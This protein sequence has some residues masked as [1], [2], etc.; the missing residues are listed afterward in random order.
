[1]HPRRRFSDCRVTVL[2]RRRSKNRASGVRYQSLRD[3]ILK[4]TSGWLI[5]IL[6][7]SVCAQTGIALAWY[8]SDRN[9]AVQRL[10]E[11]VEP[12]LTRAAW[13]V[14]QEAVDY[15]LNTLLNEARIAQVT[16]H[17]KYTGKTVSMPG[18]EPTDCI[19]TTE[20]QMAYTA[21][22]EVR[23][24]NATLVIC[25][26]AIDY[27][28]VLKFA[29]LSSIPFWISGILVA[30]ALYWILDKLVVSPISA[31]SRAL[32]KGE[33]FLQF[34]LKRASDRSDDIDVLV[35]GI[36]NRSEDLLAERDML[37]TWFHG[38]F[39]GMILI[40]H[41]GNIV[42]YNIVAK[43]VFPELAKGVTHLSDILGSPFQQSFGGKAETIF[44]HSNGRKF[45]FRN[46]P[47]KGPNQ[48]DL[49]LLVI[50]DVTEQLLVERDTIQ[51]EKL[52]SVGQL[53]VGIAHDFNNVLAVVMSTIEVLEQ[54]QGLSE[55][56]QHLLREAET[57]LETGRA[58]T[59]QLTGYSRKSDVEVKSVN[60]NE[61]VKTA[62]SMFSRGTLKNVHF[63]VET[64][65]KD[66]LSIEP[67]LLINALLN[68][69]SNACDASLP[70]STV[71]LR[72]SQIIYEDQSFVKF[73]VQDTGAGIPPEI[74]ERIFDPFFTTKP[75]KKGT[76]LGLASV[77]TFAEKRGGMLKIE[78]SLG[79]GT[80]ADM[81]FPLN[82]LTEAK[83][84]QVLPNPEERSFTAKSILIVEDNE[85][86]LNIVSLQ[87][88]AI[89]GRVDTARNLEEVKALLELGTGWDI[90][91]CDVNLGAQ[92]GSE[93]FE[94]L[95][96]YKSEAHIIFMSGGLS[97]RDIDALDAIGT[98]LK[99]EKPFKL[100]ELQDLMMKLD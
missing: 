44:D 64:S 20:H 67:N 81:L 51:K 62:H 99:I 39:D 66:P 65:C 61:L 76:G 50:R 32:Q 88:K 96:R 80:V 59:G 89:I 40:E 26:R 95:R 69:L 54:R 25:H 85:S 90:I 43:N 30:L 9:A 33:N 37:T 35:A 14:N 77:Q 79:E 15:S 98:N 18:F 53:A 70:G 36:K 55:I 92:H 47:I 71:W 93:V 11:H 22:E 68:L 27:V 38:A 100:F 34:D 46:S 52:I 12:H 60:V 5:L 42:R 48:N 2:N 45:S 6:T 73:S 1:M 7:L 82:S 19:R 21:T 86:Y 49:M 8:L 29:A 63:E 97:Q 41:N 4:S 17:E 56:E 16:F 78:S 3:K 57:A 72:C 91:L 94:E 13:Q 31:I 74:L 75:E 84:P 58:L 10:I 28:A 24:Q 83:M 23:L 87:L